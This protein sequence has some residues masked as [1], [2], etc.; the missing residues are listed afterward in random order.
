MLREIAAKF[1]LVLAEVAGVVGESDVLRATA[2]AAL[3]PVIT[4]NLL[5]P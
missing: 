5:T 4:S 1:P 2:R 3:A